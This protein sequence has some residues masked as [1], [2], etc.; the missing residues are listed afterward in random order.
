VVFKQHGEAEL[1]QYPL[2]LF[3]LDGEL[4]WPG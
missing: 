3:L 4:P 2:E 1:Y